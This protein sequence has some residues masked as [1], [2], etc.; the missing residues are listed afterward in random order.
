MRLHSIDSAERVAREAA[1][2]VAAE[3]RPVRSSEARSVLGQIAAHAGGGDVVRVVRPHPPVASVSLLAGLPPI[4]V[5]KP[6][7]AVPQRKPSGKAAS[8]RAARRAGPEERDEARRLGRMVVPRRNGHRP[9]YHRTKR[10]HSAFLTRRGAGARTA[11]C[12]SG[13][14]A[15]PSSPSACSRRRRSGRSSWPS[16]GSTSVGDLRPRRLERC[17]PRPFLCGLPRRPRA[18]AVHAQPGRDRCVGGARLGSWRAR[19]RLVGRRRR[20]GSARRSLALVPRPARPPPD[21]PL[22]WERAEARPRPLEP[23]DAELALELGWLLATD[24]LLVRSGTLDS[25]RSAR[26]WRLAHRPRRGI[27]WR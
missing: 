17:A 26:I 19:V 1:A 3:L 6:E 4:S 22:V 14:T 8:A 24:P 10:R 25:R 2:R 11:P 21:L 15:P 18:H 12:S 9:L 7:M 27:S 20:R 5:W 16:C 13:T 23:P